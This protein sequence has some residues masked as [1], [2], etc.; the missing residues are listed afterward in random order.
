[1]LRFTVLKPVVHDGETIISAG[2]PAEGR[3]TV[4]NNRKIAIAFISVEAV[5]GQKIL[6][7]KDELDGRPDK[8]LSR[9]H[10]TGVIRKGLSLVL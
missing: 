5:N 8:V 10:F 4:L 9:K 1:L 6:F 7:D 3:V 2:A